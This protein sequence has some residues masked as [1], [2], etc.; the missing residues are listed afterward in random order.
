VDS[1]KV[2]PNDTPMGLL[3]LKAEIDQI[4]ESLL[5]TTDYFI[6]GFR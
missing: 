5:Q 2:L 6:R 3:E 4:D 1:A